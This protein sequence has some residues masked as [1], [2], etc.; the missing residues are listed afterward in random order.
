LYLYPDLLTV[1]EGDYQ[2]GKLKTGRLVKLKG[3]SKEY[4]IPVPE[5]SKV[6]NQRTYSY[7]PSTANII[8][9]SP[10]L[11]D[12][13]EERYVFVSDS[14]VPMAGEGLYAKT[15]LKAGQLCALFNG[16]RQRHLCGVKG[17]NSNREW[18]DYRI[19]VEPDMDMD[20]RKEH[21]CLSNY[22]ATLGHKTCHSFNPNAYFAQVWNPRFGLLCP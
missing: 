13:Y 15:S 21:E 7:E 12:P 17:D 11:R 5:I 6:C 3:V 14:S 4:G 2:H 20:I 16:V 22:R 9:K 18:S 8:T 19:S 1:L 10:M